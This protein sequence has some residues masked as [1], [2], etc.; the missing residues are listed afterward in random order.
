MTNVS[1][2]IGGHDPAA[3]GVHLQHTTGGGIEK[4]G[5]EL[6]ASGIRAEIDKQDLQTYAVLP[7]GM[8]ET[9]TD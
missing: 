5:E 7:Q 2:L 4:V 8:L 6:G 1:G 9:D 3:T